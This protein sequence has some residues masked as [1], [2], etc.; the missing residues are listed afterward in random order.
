MDLNQQYLAEFT[1]ALDASN[2]MTM[3]WD[4]KDKLVFAGQKSFDWSE[5]AG[6]KLSPH[7]SFSDYVKTMK[8]GGG[9]T[10]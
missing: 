7:I 5:L 8:A 1:E 9:L 2:V 4:P 10:K 6:G 3:L